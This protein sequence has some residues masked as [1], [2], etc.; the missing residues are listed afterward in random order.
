MVKEPIRVKILGIAAT[1][2]REGNCHYIL[3]EGLKVVRESGYAETELIHLIDYRIEYCRGC[4]GCL[5]RV[6]RRQKEVG[7]DL[8]PVPIEGYNCTIQDDMEILHRKM[9]DSDGIIIAAP[10]YIATVPGQLKTFIDRCRTF[11]HDYRLRGKV[12][13]AITVAFF[14]NAGEDTA[15]QTMTLSL[16]AIGIT[17]VS[18][19]ASAVSTREGMGLPIKETRFAVKEDM[20]GMTAVRGVAS[21]VAVAALQIKAGRMAMEEMG[22]HV[23]TRPWFP[24]PGHPLPV[25]Q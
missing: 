22:I 9:L 11:V 18:F 4:D 21:Q 15:L 6:H 25:K 7:F 10:V 2:I 14:R 24:V 17:V 16:L 8:I 20:V 5:R 1:P 3:D 23:R 19:G 12:G 13:A